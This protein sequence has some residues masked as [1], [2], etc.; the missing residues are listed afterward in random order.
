M[1]YTN[2]RQA[3]AKIAKREAFKGN[4]MKGDTP[5]T[6]TGQLPRTWRD[7]YLDDLAR[8]MDY[9]V[10]SY[11]TPIAWHSPRF[12]WV[13]PNVKYSVTTTIQQGVVRTALADV[14]VTEGLVSA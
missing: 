4:S 11:S 1:A 9:V 8:G 5:S 10:W 6:L 7:L 3:V 14:V 12:G 2:R 13:V